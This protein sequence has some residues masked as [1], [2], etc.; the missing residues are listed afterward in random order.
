M[1]ITAKLPSGATDTSYS[2][3][4]AITFS[5]PANSPTGNAPT[6]P[7]TVSF[8]G[9]V[10]TATITLFNAAASTMLTATEATTSGSS[11]GFQI[12]A[13]N[14]RLSFSA[15]PPEHGQKGRT[16]SNETLTRGNDPYGNADPSKGISISIALT[17]NAGSWTPSSVT[18]TANGTTSGTSK[19]T[20]PPNSGVS[21][22]WTGH[23]ATNGYQDATCTYTT[24]F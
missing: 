6:Y 7:T 3:N 2:G 11:T 15:C 20:N 19:F 22:T 1:T 8:T 18:I 16:T 14:V 21:V 9:G 24:T 17:A 12:K 23:T 5:G 10:G 13:A 4:K